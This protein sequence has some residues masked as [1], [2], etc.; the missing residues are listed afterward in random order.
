MQEVCSQALEWLFFRSSI[1]ILNMKISFSPLYTREINIKN[2]HQLHNK[3]FV[4]IV[5][6][7]ILWK[8]HDAFLLKVKLNKT[9]T[10]WQPIY[11]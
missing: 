2:R 10:S 8:L 7:P 3:G 6:L 4:E 9:P 5:W 1:Y 11:D